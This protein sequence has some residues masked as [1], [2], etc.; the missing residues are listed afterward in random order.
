VPNL[1]VQS[2]KSRGRR[3]SLTSQQWISSARYTSKN[4]FIPLWVKLR[5]AGGKKEA[6]K[7]IIVV[8]FTDDC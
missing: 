5:L 7:V 3:A 2:Q 8:A 1:G 6:D 4:I